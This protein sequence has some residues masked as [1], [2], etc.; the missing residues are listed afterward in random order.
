MSAH[1]P[2]IEQTGKIDTTPKNEKKFGHEK[3]NQPAQPV[4]PVVMMN[5]VTPGKKEKVD[6]GQAVMTRNFTIK[7]DGTVINSDYKRNEYYD[8]DDYSKAVKGEY[9]RA[10]KKYNTE[11]FKA[12]EEHKYASGSNVMKDGAAIIV[13]SGVSVDKHK[14]YKCRVEQINPDTTTGM[15]LLVMDWDVSKGGMIY[16]IEKKFYM[17]GFSGSIQVNLY[18]DGTYNIVKTHGKSLIFEGKLPKME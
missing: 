8:A 13:N 7:R 9:L 15:Y 11:Y 16:E 17:E 6:H 1:K 14:R 18:K 12:M 10:M 4:R 3:T 5:I 2:R